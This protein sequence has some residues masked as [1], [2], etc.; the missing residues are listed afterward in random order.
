MNLPDHRHQK[1]SFLCGYRQIAYHSAPT[2][3]SQY[4]S[5]TV[6][7]HTKFSV[8]LTFEKDPLDVCT[9][10]VSRCASA[11]LEW[12]NNSVLSVFGDKKPCAPPCPPPRPPRPGIAANVCVCVC[13]CVCEC[14]CLSVWCN[15]VCVPYVNKLR[16]N[17]WAR[18]KLRK[19]V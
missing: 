4:F 19:N 15:C 2:E 6:I 1:Q 5:V 7:F 8:K 17:V 9:R 12:C 11:G 18:H 13:V 3:I 10:S 16:K 14:V